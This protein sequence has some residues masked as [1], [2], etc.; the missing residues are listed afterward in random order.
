[1]VKEN[2]KITNFFK[3]TKDVRQGCLLS[4]LL[5]FINGI[6]NHADQ[7]SEH[8]IQIWG[9]ESVN[10]QMFPDDLKKLILVYS[11]FCKEKNRN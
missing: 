1:M 6:L 9:N 3:F 5:F 2:N 10:A 4:P 11:D 7:I 8:P